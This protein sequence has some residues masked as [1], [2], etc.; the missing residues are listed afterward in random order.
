MG[1]CFEILRS[2]SPAYG[3]FLKPSN[4]VL[5]VQSSD[6]LMA[7]DLFCNLGNQLSFSLGVVGDQSLVA[8]FVS[9]KLQFGVAIFS[10]FLTLPCLSPR[11]LLQP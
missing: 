1:Q 6:I 3:Y 4:T 11:H 7:N 2:T 5:V 8:D 9:E 10:N